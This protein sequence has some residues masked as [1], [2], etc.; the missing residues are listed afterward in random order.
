[1][2]ILL[3]ST[4]ADQ[5][6]GRGGGNVAGNT[7]F[8]RFALFNNGGCT[9]N[10]GL[11]TRTVQQGGTSMVGIGY[12]AA[13]YN[14]SANS[15]TLVGSSAGANS[16]SN[17]CKTAI[18]TFA[19]Y[20]QSPQSTSI[21]TSVN[22]GNTNKLQSVAM[23]LYANCAAYGTSVGHRAGQYR[24]SAFTINIGA[25]AG[26]F[27]TSNQ[28]NISI[29]HYTGRFTAGASNI[30]HVGWYAYNHNGY[31]TPDQSSIGRANN[32]TACVWVGW[33]FAS[34]SRDKSNITPLS[35]NL[36]INF[37]RKLR[38]VTFNWDKRIEY[39]DKCGYE[40][41]IKD[42]T[43]AETKEDYGFI[44]Q[45]V[46]V[47]AQQVQEKFDALAYGDYQDA[48]SVAHLEFV[49]VLTKA[50]QK[51]NDDLDLIENHLNS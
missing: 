32:Q 34:D 37:V 43:L 39:Y 40:Y 5:T 9:A 15:N 19:A 21:G 6:F 26:Q 36:G 48:Y 33:S 49:A 46:E 12:R 27:N 44:A 8:G 35:D 14:A 13:V 30:I 17:S 18:G 22:S 11:G 1:M 29:G 41:G 16:Y 28:A 42:G 4:V 47:A 51:I 38:P 50:L 7:A 25:F 45:E 23:G 24:T 20:F 10:A 2:A 3:E 31:G